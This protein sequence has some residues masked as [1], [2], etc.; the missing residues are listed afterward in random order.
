MSGIMMTMM[1]VILLNLP[2]SFRWVCPQMTVRSIRTLIRRCSIIIDSL[3]PNT[4]NSEPPRYIVSAGLMRT[5]RQRYENVGDRVRASNVSAAADELAVDMILESTGYVVGDATRRQ[6]RSRRL[7]ED[8][9][10]DHR[11]SLLT[12]R[13]VAP[14]ELHTAADPSRHLA[15]SCPAREPRAA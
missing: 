7:D 2:F 4:S 14:I 3:P 9:G 10:A 15:L 8:V 6:R 12:D 1:K 11:L 5:T 13:S